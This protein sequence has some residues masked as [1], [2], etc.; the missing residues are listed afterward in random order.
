[1]KIHSLP[2]F[3][4][5]MDM[6]P[7]DLYKDLLSECKY[8][9]IKNPEFTS[10][11][12]D[13]DVAQHR[14]VV[15]NRKKLYNYIKNVLEEYRNRYKLSSHVR[16]FTN[17]L[18][19]HF[20]TPWINFQKKSQ[21]LPIHTHDGVYSYNIWLKIPKTCRFEFIYTNIIGNIEPF[22]ITLT[23]EDEG[24]IIFFP[25]KLPHIAY[26]FNDS[27]DVRLSIAGNISFKS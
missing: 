23:K 19:F 3:G 4:F 15:E 10:G 9:Q 27:D 25:A 18:P 21:Y 26:P 14:Y 5:I 22:K 2:N 1:M 12:T 16:V 8:A 13:L 11:I 6:I 7:N 24:K 20:D 17:D